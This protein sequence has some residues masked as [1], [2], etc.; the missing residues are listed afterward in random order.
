MLKTDFDS[1]DQFSSQEQENILES[2]YNK[3]QLECAVN[4]CDEGYLPWF[5]R[6]GDCI[7]ISPSLLKVR[8]KKFTPFFLF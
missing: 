1:L 3:N 5:G 4:P 2:F 7:K 8:L 6:P